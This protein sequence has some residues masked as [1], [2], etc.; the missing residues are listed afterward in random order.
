MEIN[1]DCIAE[2]PPLLIFE[3]MKNCTY[4]FC[5]KN[6][7]LN[8]NI[9]TKNYLNNRTSKINLI[10]RISDKL[11]FKSQTFF[12]AIYYFD[13][14]K[15]ESNETLTFNNY[16]SLALA[17]LIIASKY[18]ENDPM[19]PQLPYFIRAYNSVV[20][21]KNRNSIAISDLIYNE[22]KICKLLNYK[23]QYYTIYDYNSF[24][25]SHG[26]LKSDQLKEIKI[27]NNLSFS[28]YAKKVLEKIYHKSRYYLD[29]IINKEESFKYNSLLISIYIMQKSVETVIINESKIN[30][31]IEKYKIK[32]RTHKYFKEI[33]NDFYKINY[34]SMEEYHLMKRDFEPHKYRNNNIIQ[35]I[36]NIS[37]NNNIQ[38][39]L[40]L[41]KINELFNNCNADNNKKIINS[42]KKNDNKIDIYR[43]SFNLPK[44]IKENKMKT[45]ENKS[46]I[47]SKTDIIKDAKFF[48][49]S[50]E[51]NNDLYYS[52]NFTN[53]KS[54]NNEINDKKNNKLRGK[55]PLSL[56]LNKYYS[57]QSLNN[58]KKEKNMFHYNN[59]IE[60]LASSINL[61]N[62]NYK[63]DFAKEIG[64]VIKS[65]SISP[66]N[67]DSKVYQFSYI[68]KRHK[69]NR[70]VNQKLIQTE[71]NKVNNKDF[72]NNISSNIN[73]KNKNTGQS[74]INSINKLYFKKVLYNIGE[75][76]KTSYSTKNKMANNMIN[77][78]NNNNKINSDKKL[79]QNIGIVNIK[80]K[81]DENNLNIDKQNKEIVLS[82]NNND[83]INSLKNNF[84]EKKYINNK[85]TINNKNI[86]YNKINR[87]NI[88]TNDTYS[89]LK[90]DTLNSTE[91]NNINSYLGKLKQILNEKKNNIILYRDNNGY[92][93]N[94]K[95]FYTKT[96]ANDNLSSTS[97]KIK[98]YIRNK[99]DKNDNKTKNK[100]KINLKQKATTTLL[101]KQHS[102]S[103]SKINVLK[104]E[105]NNDQ[106]D[107]NKLN[108]KEYNI[109]TFLRDDKNINN[110]ININY[111]SNNSNKN[112]KFINT[113]NKE[114]I[115]NKNKLKKNNNINNNS[116]KLDK[117]DNDIISLNYKNT[118]S[119][120]LNLNNIK[121]LNINGK[122]QKYKECKDFNFDELNNKNI[123]G[124]KYCPFISTNNNKKQKKLNTKN[125]IIEGGQ[126]NNK[127]NLFSTIVINNNI[128]INL[129]KELNNKENIKYKKKSSNTL[130]HF[131]RNGENNNIKKVG[132]Y[133]KTTE[134]LNNK[135]LKRIKNQ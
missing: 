110:N 117:I 13:I 52:L 3:K 119:K 109:I 28:L 135:K 44:Y 76:K 95:E 30:N 68:N 118:L 7:K 73:T 78:C 32:K 49:L 106:K 134:N 113:S 133:H 70:L 50:K 14:I 83:N 131:F 104:T 75:K 1:N 58:S 105:N 47:S 64:N 120:S 94:K 81:C 43:N 129:N 82:F 51:N 114:Q 101:N 48:F 31:D 9:I 89:A 29:I 56:S 8:I 53:N 74:N 61:N 85:K 37:I 57:I 77:T 123:K 126:F 59:T 55:K 87:Q 130:N 98:N 96:E 62:N 128:N 36:N 116:N 11:G 93:K 92:L 10:K 19:V 67:I 102:N 79:K 6:K 46:I 60:N 112:K 42:Y 5:K 124:D 97:N 33:M 34:E 88:F 103:N 84:F 65:K 127:R 45:E 71:E 91:N 108:N 107:E 20:E 63:N 15:I 99:S 40:S 24:F 35:N 66:N 17:C 69:I 80:R 115:N 72:K 125:N 111:Y 25:F 26:I 27:S 12:L 39:D 132:I 22:L 100:I 38:K 90:I 23:L 2:I 54:N 4:D 41:V 122:K 16:N 86:S 121:K 21:K 18:C